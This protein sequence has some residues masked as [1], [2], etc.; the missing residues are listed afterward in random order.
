M[1]RKN[2]LLVHGALRHSSE[3]HETGV[4][5]EMKSLSVFPNDSSTHLSAQMNDLQ[6]N[7]CTGL[8]R[9]T[10]HI[11]QVGATTENLSNIKAIKE[12]FYSYLHCKEMDF[13]PLKT[14][15]KLNCI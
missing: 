1:V 6:L 14:D 12:L 2:K 4:N 8:N 3:L 10:L 7:K 5:R 15:I 13:N 9:L 11:K